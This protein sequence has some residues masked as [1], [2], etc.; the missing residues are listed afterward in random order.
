[1]LELHFNFYYKLL[2]QYDFN[3]LN[4]LEMKISTLQ[5]VEPKSYTD[6]FAVTQDFYSPD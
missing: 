6:F 3:R 4:K 5:K 2:L 1:M